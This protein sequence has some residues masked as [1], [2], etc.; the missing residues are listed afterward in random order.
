M[1][2]ARLVMLLGHYVGGR[3]YVREERVCGHGCIIEVV[4]N[5]SRI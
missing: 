4:V 1:P 5:I 3:M 2:H